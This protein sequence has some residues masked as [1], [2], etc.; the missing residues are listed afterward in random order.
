MR[1]GALLIF[2]TALL[3]ACAATPERGPAPAPASASRPAP[4]PA[5]PTEAPFP[6]APGLAEVLARAAEAPRTEAAALVV[7]VERGGREQA[8]LP[9]N[10]E[11]STSGERLGS[12]MANRLVPRWRTEAMQRIETAG[13]RGARVAAAEGRIRTSEAMARAERLA[14]AKEAALLHQRVIALSALLALRTERAS[15][16]AELLALRER[17]FVSGRAGEA[18]VPP[19]RAR[20]GERKAAVLEDRAE[21]AATLRDLEGLLA[22]PP[23]SVSGASGPLLDVAVLPAGGEGVADN[24]ETTVLRAER[25]TA[26][27]RLESEEAKAIP[28]VTVSVGVENEEIGRRGTDFMGMVGV[29]MP[30]PLFDRNQGAIAAARAEVRRAEVLLREAEARALAAEQG[31]LRAAEELTASRRVLASEALPARERELALAEAAARGGRTDLAPA[32]EAR[33][34]VLDLREALV[35]RDLAIAEMLVRLLALRGL[36]PEEWAAGGEA[37][38]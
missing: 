23:G 12:N 20:L 21:I 1:P 29:S 24:P 27:A 10:P 35:E 5:T 9:P 33:L 3:A 2:G 18:E 31:L 11:L 30:L 15:A 32:I 6:A 4:L 34:A 37:G 26:A 16:T 22:L 28:D 25:T 19:L 17:Q 14:V 7:E 8:A 13:K 38:R 36:E